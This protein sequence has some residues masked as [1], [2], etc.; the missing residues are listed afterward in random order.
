MVLCTGGLAACSLQ[1]SQHD[2]VSVVEQ[3]LKAKKMNDYQAWKST[4]WAAQKDPKNFVPS[5]EAPGFLGVLSLSITG[6][7][8]SD[9]ET[10]RIKKMYF[11]SDL[12]KSYGWSDEYIAN[13][14]V[15]VS[16][17]Y[18]VDYDNTRVPYSEGPISQYFYLVKDNQSSLWLIW[19]F[20]SQSE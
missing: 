19:D 16:A 6:V 13:N 5:F 9:D 3:Y 12:A 14:M 8:V 10:E 20:S 11:G 1:I 18:T 4:L 7:S 15:A 17:Q 2:A